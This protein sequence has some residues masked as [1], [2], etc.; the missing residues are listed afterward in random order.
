MGH[1]AR[2][3]GPVHRPLEVAGVGS[4]LPRLLDGRERKAELAIDKRAWGLAARPGLTC[5]SRLRVVGF[6]LAVFVKSI[7]DE[8]AAGERQ[9]AV[10]LSASLT[11]ALAGM[12]AT[13]LASLPEP[14]RSG[15]DVADALAAG[16]VELICLRRGAEVPFW[17]RSGKREADPWWFALDNPRLR[18]LIVSETPP[19]LA[20][21][22]VFIS[23][24]SLASV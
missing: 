16:L 24:R 18:P 21:R 9:M 23:E 4:A 6:D 1:E 3:R 14:A 17:C 22:G 12:D 11:T 7:A 10:R 5:A 19:S 15:D 13:E 20:V 8:L 2:N